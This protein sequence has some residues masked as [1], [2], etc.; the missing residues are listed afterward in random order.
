M[1]EI[2][3]EIAPDR[4]DDESTVLTATIFTGVLHTCLQQRNIIFIEM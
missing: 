3:V 4:I 2:A 1:I